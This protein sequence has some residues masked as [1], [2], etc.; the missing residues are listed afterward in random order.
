MLSEL[1]YT[2]GENGRIIEK[3]AKIA[4]RTNMIFAFSAISRA[5]K[6]ENPLDTSV[7]G[8]DE[9]SKATKIR[10]R[11]TH[12]KSA[13]MLE[14]TDAELQSVVTAYNFYLT[15]MMEVHKRILMDLEAKVAKFEAL[16]KSHGIQYDE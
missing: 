11:L 13:E 9:L 15:S 12:P 5:E 16:L 2:I 10:D 8:W 4:A 1:T 6:I 14:V 3:P 7:S